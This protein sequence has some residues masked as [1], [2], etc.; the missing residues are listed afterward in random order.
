VPPV[1]AEISPV[2]IAEPPVVADQQT[3]LS[4]DQIDAAVERVVRNLF[5]EKI[6]P[7]LNEIVSTA[8]HHEIENLK[9]VFLEYLASGKTS[10][11]G[12]STRQNGY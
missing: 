12:Y 10:L 8:V 2:R 6:E 9:T 3:A 5:D 11:K 4:P 7:I 1:V